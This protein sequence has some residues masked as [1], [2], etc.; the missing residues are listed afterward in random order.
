MGERSERE[1]RARIERMDGWKEVN[2]LLK[3]PTGDPNTLS[4]YRPISHLP[5]PAKVMEKVINTQL[6]DHL[7]L[8]Q[9]LD[10]SQSGFRT[11]HSTETALIA[12]TDDIR[13]IL[14]HGET[15]AL[16]LLDL[17]AAFNTVSHKSLIRKLQHLGICGPALK[18]ISSFL[19][20]RTQ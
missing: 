16:I 6:A 4:R 9:L 1:K 14:D 13:S 19:T 11:N 3:K 15:A 5:F 18:W 20:D 2:A 8:H 12:A 7:E 10:S 17:S